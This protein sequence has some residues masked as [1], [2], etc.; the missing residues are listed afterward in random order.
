MSLTPTPLLPRLQ[1]FRP[2]AERLG[3]APEV[4]RQ[5]DACPPV[6]TIGGVEHADLEGLAKFEVA[7]LIRAWGEECA[8]HRVKVARLH[9]ARVVTEKPAG[10]AAEPETAAA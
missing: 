8:A 9:A 2:F 10:V 3:V 1:P 6:V 5:D 4:L 7:L